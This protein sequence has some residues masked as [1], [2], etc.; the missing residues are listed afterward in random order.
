MRNAKNNLRSPTT[1]RSLYCAWI[2]LHD[3]GDQLISIWI[4]PTL[5][6]F[7]TADSRGNAADRHTCDYL[8]RARN[9]VQ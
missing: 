8:C 9:G 5:T 2:P 7:S 3:S 1:D 4:D 6:A